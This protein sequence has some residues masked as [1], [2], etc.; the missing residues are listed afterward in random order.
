MVKYSFIIPVKAIN[1]YI[2]E[3]VS[4]ILRFRRN[5][6]EIIIYPDEQSGVVWSHTRQIAT[7][8]C[9]PAQKRNLAMWDAQGEVLIFIDDDSYPE[10]NFLEI[11][12]AD[13]SDEKVL[14]VGGP[15]ITPPHDGFWQKVSG[16]VFLSALS[17]GY[18][19]RYASIG[20]KKFVDDWPSVNLSVR[21]NVFKDIGGFRSDYWPGE[22][23]KFCL[24]LVQK[25]DSQI[26]YDPSLVVFH[27]RR[28]GLLQHVRQISQYGIHRGFFAK[29]YPQTSFKFKYFLPSFFLLFVVFG[30][31]LSFFSYLFLV[32]Y[33]LGWALYA[34]A[35]IRSFF[36]IYRY[37][38]NI[39]IILN[40]LYYI[41]ITHL[42]YGWRFIQG[43]V[44]V[45]E[46]K[47]KFR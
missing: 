23:T 9:G 37:E 19:E 41:F 22:D 24:D 42:F 18:P 32:L 3:T 21:R 7:G 35:L 34:M 2:E 38:K 15:G 25:R 31:I 1:N 43:F 11:L 44:F 45:Q 30:G 4:H 10:S 33:M 40:A 5:D 14:A 12:D 47:S 17:G 36:D 29:K 20:A 28:A 13:F 16:A 8:A 26:L 46:L 6:F 39:V 27:H